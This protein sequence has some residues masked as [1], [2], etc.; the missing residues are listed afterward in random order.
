MVNNPIRTKFSL[1][2]LVMEVQ[3]FE[4]GDYTDQILATVFSM[5]MNK[6]RQNYS[7][8]RT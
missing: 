1:D 2:P 8:N 4:D 5:N 7:T 3:L 6:G